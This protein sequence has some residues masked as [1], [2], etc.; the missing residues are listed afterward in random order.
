ME[1][2]LMKI[3]LRNLAMYRWREENGMSQRLAA[4]RAG[5]NYICWNAYECLRTP[6]LKSKAVKDGLPL[7]ACWKTTALKI[8]DFM[9]QDPTT[10]WTE[11][12]R[13]VVTPTITMAVAGESLALSMR[14]FNPTPVQALEHQDLRLTLAKAV[15]SLTP[16]E[17]DMI[18]L[19]Y[20]EGWGYKEIGAKHCITK[21][22]VAE[23]VNRGLKRMK[24]SHGRV[25][26][27]HL[28]D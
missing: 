14:D 11:A 7:P 8:S 1:D 5:V 21:T 9:G 13:Q 19:R 16:R 2:L 24:K 18:R 15:Q 27:E 28:Y 10:I 4:E 22:R 20:V 6:P 3:S 23:I 17:E 26:E 25:L 12:V